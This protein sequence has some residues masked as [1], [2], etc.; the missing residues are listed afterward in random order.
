MKV[1][2]SL[3]LVLALY[4]CGGL[5]CSDSEDESQDGVSISGTPS[6]V[7]TET[8]V[9]VPTPTSEPASP[10]DTP[11]P[12]EEAEVIFYRPSTPPSDH[13]M[14]DAC[15]LPS[16]VLAREG[17]WRCGPPPL[18]PCFGEVGEQEVI[19]PGRP[20]PGFGVLVELA[21]PLVAITLSSG[22][23]EHQASQAWF[24]L[25][26]DGRLCG[27]KAGGTSPVVNGERV[28]FYC[29][30]ATQT[31]PGTGLVGL[32]APGVVW[33]AEQVLLPD[34]PAPPGTPVPAGTVELRIVWR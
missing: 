12:V 4:L 19:C 18:D 25:T 11:R 32:P 13:L 1:F 31:F 26:A 9:S 15:V 23:L 10:T 28:N 24:V 6:P 20:E 3:G 30:D 2:A 29:D 17:V 7:R 5:A 27:F 33:T 21:Q 22:A 8:P 34:T 14:R 16:V